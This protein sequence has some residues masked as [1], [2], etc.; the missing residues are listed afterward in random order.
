MKQKP[1]SPIPD[2]LKSS[3][4]SGEGF[5]GTDTRSIQEIIDADKLELKKLGIAKKKLV[6]A[7]TSAFEK[8]QSQLGVD[9]EIAPSV[10]AIY[11]ESRGKIPSPFRADGSFDKGEV[12]VTNST[13][14][15]SITL[16]RLSINLIDKHDF[17]QGIGSLYRIDPDKAVAVFGLNHL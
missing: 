13:S 3:I 6:A 17:F 12:V 5:L 1:S 14:G 2:E 9:T 4:F 10:T 16:T 7:L 8:A 15:E 11:H